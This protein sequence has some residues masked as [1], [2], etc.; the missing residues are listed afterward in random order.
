[1]RWLHYVLAMATLA[2]GVG[3][4]AADW[5]AGVAKTVITPKE[6]MWMGVLALHQTTCRGTQHDLYVKALALEDGFVRSSCY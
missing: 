2:L 5:K 3:T 6:P 4:C 1:M